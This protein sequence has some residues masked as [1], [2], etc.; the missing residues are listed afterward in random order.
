MVAYPHGVL[1]LHYPGWQR[2]AEGRRLRAV[3]IAILDPVLPR[4]VVCQPVCGE[5]APVTS[6][7]SHTEH[8]RLV[9]LGNPHEHVLIPSFLV[10]VE[11]LAESAILLANLHH[12][13]TGVQLQDGEWVVLLIAHLHRQHLPGQRGLMLLYLRS[14]R[15]KYES[16]VTLY[17]MK[18][19]SSHI[20]AS[21]DSLWRRSYT[22]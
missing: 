8:S 4:H 7:Y 10:G 2:N 5:G 18:R 15:V 3:R 9:G 13:G 22:S 6:H 12:T 17:I 14:K 16:R 19:R 21:T 1:F 20:T 11:Y